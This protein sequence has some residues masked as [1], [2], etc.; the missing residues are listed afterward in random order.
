MNIQMSQLRR[1]KL[2]FSYIYVII[3]GLGQQ[4][5]RPGRFHVEGPSTFRIIEFANICNR[6]EGILEN[7]CREIPK[8]EGI[9]GMGYKIWDMGYFIWDKG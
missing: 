7:G 6:S 4:V 5:R 1:F 8:G 3:R 9:R 2:L